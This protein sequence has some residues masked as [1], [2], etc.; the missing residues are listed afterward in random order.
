MSQDNGLR[1]YETIL[2]HRLVLIITSDA[3]PWKPNIQKWLQINRGDEVLYMVWL[4][5]TP[6]H[7]SILVFISDLR[8]LIAE[9]SFD[10]SIDGDR[11]T[12]LDLED[13]LIDL[14][15]DIV[16]RQNEVVLVLE[17]YHHIQEPAIHAALQMMLEF[18]PTNFHVLITSQNRPP[19]AL[20]RL[21]L[22]GQMVEL[23]ERALNE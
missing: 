15:N 17:D 2:H 20:A 10:T 1:I 3:N 22:L 8:A 6:R 19:L 4:T 7:N 16:E 21:H 23:E 18:T 5:L 12:P 9:A 11:L 14:M 13:Y